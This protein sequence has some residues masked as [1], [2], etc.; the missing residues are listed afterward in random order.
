[1]TN[2]IAEDAGAITGKTRCP[3]MSAT[4]G[5]AAKAFATTCSGLLSGTASLR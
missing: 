2:G 1:V 4:D 5:S 3:T